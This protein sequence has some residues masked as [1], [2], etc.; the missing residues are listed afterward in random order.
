MSSSRRESS[1]ILKEYG[2]RLF[3]AHAS[4]FNAEEQ[5]SSSTPIFARSSRRIARRA[6][7]LCAVLILVMALAVVICSAFGIQLFNYR[8]DYRDGHIIITSLE[9]ENGQHFYIPDY[10][11]SGYTFDDVVESAEA[12]RFYVFISE[13][14][15]SSY[16]VEEGFDNK[17]VIYADNDG[18]DESTIIYKEYELKVFKDKSSSFIN[19]YL[20][21][22][23]TFISIQGDLSIEQ[24]YTIIDGLIV[25]DTYHPN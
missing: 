14:G 15:K 13:D 2:K 8:F 1:K 11:V 24:I 9:A 17:T 12:T 4:Y 22:G 23:G 3:E 19:V 25:D 7:V 10:V 21:K 6:L 5:Q 20:E 16:I 18:Y